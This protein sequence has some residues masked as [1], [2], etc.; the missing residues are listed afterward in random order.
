MS[1]KYVSQTIGNISNATIQKSSQPLFNYGHPDYNK[2]DNKKA[3]AIYY[4]KVGLNILIQY[5][6]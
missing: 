3:L 2:K 4:V 1:I 6:T 5:N